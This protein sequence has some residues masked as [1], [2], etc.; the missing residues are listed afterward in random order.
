MTDKKLLSEVLNINVTDTKVVDNY[1][2]YNTHYKINVYELANLCK[3]WALKNTGYRLKSY[4]N[5]KG[6]G[7]CDVR[8]GDGRTLTRKIVPNSEPEA[9]FQACN[10]IIKQKE[11]K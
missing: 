7:I 5:D 1:I 9:I 8:V 2:I 6:T 10:W 11:T 3:Q 4:I